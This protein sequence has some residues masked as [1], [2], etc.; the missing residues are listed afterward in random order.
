[1]NQQEKIVGTRISTTYQTTIAS[2]NFFKGD[3]KQK[4]KKRGDCCHVSNHLIENNLTTTFVLQTFFHSS[5][6]D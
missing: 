1:M 6:L 2:S 4:P 5:A 3:R